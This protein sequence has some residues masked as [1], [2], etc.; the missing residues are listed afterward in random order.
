MKQI[1]IRQ[2]VIFFIDLADYVEYLH[3]FCINKLIY[4]DNR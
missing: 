3:Y 1:I 4:Y 2:I